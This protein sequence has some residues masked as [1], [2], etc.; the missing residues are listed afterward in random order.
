MLAAEAEQAPGK[1]FNLG[2]GR[3]T[4]LLQLLRLL[5]ELLGKPVTPQFEPPRAGD[6]RESMADI[7]QARQLIGYE[8]KTTL[9]EG[10]RLT[11]D[12][13]RQVATQKLSATK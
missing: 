7:S 4:S 3:Q 8:P 2:A 11:I 5:S 12:Y 13:Y 6:V 1:I 9:E 10:L